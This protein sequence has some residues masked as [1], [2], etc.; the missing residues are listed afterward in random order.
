MMAITKSMEQRWVVI[1]IMVKVI[2]AKER[3]ETRMTAKDQSKFALTS[4]RSIDEEEEVRWT[5]IKRKRRSKRGRNFGTCG[6]ST[7]TTRLTK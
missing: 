2:M 3:V 1:Q 7:R 5:L 4:S 6:N